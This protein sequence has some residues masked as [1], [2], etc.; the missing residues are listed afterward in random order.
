MRV[1]TKEA[2]VQRAV[3]DTLHF[4]GFRAFRINSG[5]IKTAKG[6]V[7]RLADKGTSDVLSLIP[8]SG[9]FF[10]IE[11]KRPGAA[12]KTTEAQDEFLA[13]ITEDG[14]V[15]V[16]I[17]DV[18]KLDEVMRILRDDPWARINREGE[19]CASETS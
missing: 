5:L 18:R 2:P 19:R 8:R 6:H 11:V 1:N 13:A 7:I 14:G 12:N 4:Y 9:R 15:A 17:D 16:V 10:A 3:I